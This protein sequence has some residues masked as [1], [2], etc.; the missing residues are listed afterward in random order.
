MIIPIWLNILIWD[1]SFMD[2]IMAIGFGYRISYYL[3]LTGF[4]LWFYKD[5]II[6]AYRI[7][8][9]KIEGELNRSILIYISLPIVGYALELIMGK[10]AQIILTII[11]RL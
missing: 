8:T 11:Y 3:I 10:I 9:K 5:K 2:G 4:I 7:F 6:I 1:I